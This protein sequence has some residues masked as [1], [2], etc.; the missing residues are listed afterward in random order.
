MQVLAALI[1]GTIFGFG[2]ALSQMIDPAKVLGFLDVAGEWDP[3]LAFVMIG[4]IAVTMLS[5]RLILKRDLP[6]WGDRF[7]VPTRNEL[8]A[9]L[10][11][12]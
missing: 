10:L 3:S 6:L 1:S 4:A 8:D 11:G 2:L 9:R 5:F 7:F 12:G